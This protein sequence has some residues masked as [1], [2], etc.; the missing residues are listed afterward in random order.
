M[1]GGESIAAERV[2]H[3]EV[4]T[5]IL[6]GGR[7]TRARGISTV[8]PK[9]MLPVGGRPILWHIM[10]L[11][12]AQC[13]TDFVLAL[14]WLGEE[15]R[16]F[17][18]N[19]EPPDD[20]W[21]VKCLDTGVDALTG[22]RVRRASRHLGGGTIMVTYGDCV[23]DIDIDGLLR[24]HRQQGRLATVTAVHPPGRF[25]EL[26][27][28]DAGRVTEFVE[29]PQTSAGTISGGFMVFERDAIDRYIPADRDVMLEREPMTAL[30][31]DGQLSGYL[32][33]GFWQPMD[34]P[35]EHELLND[36]W[37]NG[38]APWKIWT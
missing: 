1:T 25:G 3:G 9:P 26:K 20:V 29:K 11:Y 15:I 24:Y 21:R 18:E 16:K 8:M 33:E 2:P 30:V 10:K 13:H 12:G 19:L 37:E 6:C 17:M 7:G 27:V 4:P 36:L 38:K 32:H 35:R 23:G 31:D 28:D 22:T 34:T 5:I 14:G